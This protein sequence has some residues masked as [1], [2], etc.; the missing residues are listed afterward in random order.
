MTQEQFNEVS[1]YFYKLYDIMQEAKEL[2][3]EDLEDLKNKI[4]LIFSYYNYQKEIIN[5]LRDINSNWVSEFDQ[6]K[7]LH[8]EDDLKLPEIYI[9][10][11]DF[12]QNIKSENYI[13]CGKIKTKLLNKF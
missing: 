9:L 7:L 6:D 2:K 12:V 5:K 13:E 1:S 3:D 4:E 8:G 10:F 11:R